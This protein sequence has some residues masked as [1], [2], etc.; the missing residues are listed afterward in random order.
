[1]DDINL[2][3]NF[4]LAETYVSRTFTILCILPFHGAND[5]NTL[6]VETYLVDHLVCFYLC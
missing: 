6:F 4:I 2:I 3:C 5:I 1:M